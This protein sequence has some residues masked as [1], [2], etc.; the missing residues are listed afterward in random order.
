MEEETQ[1]HDGLDRLAQAHLIGQQGGVARHQKG[2][3][4]ELVGI[5]GEGQP[6]LPAGK[7]R[8][9]RWLQQV[10]QPFLEDNGVAG[11]TQSSGT[12]L[13]RSGGRFDFERNNPRLLAR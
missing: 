1:G 12:F 8:F 6:H 13:D 9:E 5:R 3:A 7:D 11:R 4:F 2:N 10:E